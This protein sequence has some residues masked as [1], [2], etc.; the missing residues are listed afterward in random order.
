MNKA[1]LVDLITLKD[2]PK[3]HGSFIRKN[4]LYK[5]KKSLLETIYNE[6]QFNLKSIENYYGKQLSCLRIKDL[7]FFDVYTKEYILQWIVTVKRKE[8]L[9]CIIY[10]LSTIKRFLQDHDNV[11]YFT[12]ND[13][14]KQCQGTH[15]KINLVN[16][17]DSYKFSLHNIFENV[18]YYQNAKRNIY[19]NSKIILG[20]RKYDIIDCLIY[21][22]YKLKDLNIKIKH[23]KY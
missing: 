21:N 7:G 3:K 20:F 13:Q 15:I 18:I 11:D 1:S 22:S 8:A 10:C 16:F 4:E 19:I 5:L 17:K 12:F 9:Q 6:I 14:L 23:F 2:I